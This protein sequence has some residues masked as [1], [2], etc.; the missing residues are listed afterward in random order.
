VSVFVIGSATNIDR[1]ILTL[2]QLILS[3]EKN[4]KREHKTTSAIP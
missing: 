3:A 4:N 2:L 1:I